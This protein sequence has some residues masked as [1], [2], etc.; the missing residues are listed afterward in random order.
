[1]ALTTE[2][3]KQLREARRLIEAPSFAVRLTDLLGQPIDKGVRMLPEK[4]VQ[5]LHA[6]VR[7]ALERSLDLALRSMGSRSTRTSD[8]RLHKLATATTGAVGGFFGLSGVAVELPLTTTIMLR[9]IGDIARSEG[10]DLRDTETRLACLEVFALGGRSAADDAAETGYYAVR[11][12]LG[13]VVSDAARYVAEHGL[14]G[15]G[16]PVLVRLIESVAAR[17][18]IV[19]QEKVALELIPA[20]GAVTGAVI[21]TVFMSHFQNMARGHF[22]IRRLEAVH[23]FEVVRAAY[24]NQSGPKT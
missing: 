11:T 20:I 10:H 17:F 5:R 22:I 2:E 15:R 3:L 6:I 19:V 7:A 16:G 8:D 9:S 23:G 18:G 1:M 12:S 4:A 13:A 21:N 24:E 14:R